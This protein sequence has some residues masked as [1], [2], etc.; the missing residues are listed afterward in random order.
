MKYVAAY[1]LL[2]MSGKKEVSE[3]DLET[4]FKQID[5]DF[6]SET[7]KTVVSSL[8]GKELHELVNNGLSKVGSIGG[9]SSNNNASAGGN[10]KKEEK[11]EEKVEE[12]EE[13]IDMGGMFD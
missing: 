4:F 10:D 13:D 3:K 9:G 7:A 5:S 12:E 11:V 1:T 2:M 8:K 6:D